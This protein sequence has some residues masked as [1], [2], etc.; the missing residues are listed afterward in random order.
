MEEYI[1]NYNLE[2][3]SSVVQGRIIEINGTILEKVLCLLIGEIAVGGDDSSDFSP[4]RYFK[5]VCR[6]LRGAKRIVLTEE[7]EHELAECCI[8][9]KGKFDL[10]EYKDDDKGPGHYTKGHWA[11]ATT[12]T[13]VKMEDLEEPV[14]ALIDHGSEINIMS[15]EVY[16][17][18]RWPIDINHGWEIRTANNTQ[19]DLYGACP[20][21]K[22]KVGDV[23][24]EQ[25]FFVQETTSYSVILGQPYITAVRMETKVLDDGSACARIRS[26]DGKKTVQFL[27]VLTNHEHNRNYLRSD[28]L[29]RVSEEFKDF[30]TLVFPQGRLLEGI[31]LK[32]A[33]LKHISQIYCMVQALDIKGSSKQDLEDSKKV[34]SEQNRR[35]EE[36][37]WTINEIGESKL[38]LEQKLVHQYEFWTKE[39]EHILRIV[40]GQWKKLIQNHKTWN[41]KW[42]KLKCQVQAERDKAELLTKEKRNIE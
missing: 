4:G 36:Q 24:T 17:R 5:E 21:M 29:P 19:G 6:P 18:G 28:L 10:D 39:K 38:I 26:Q 15:K 20:N 27:T 22:V 7:E 14:I 8:N 2:D 3:G 41:L 25:K 34:I 33:L 35:I 30:C 16:K 23:A 37:E 1:T 11:R 13:L 32:N 42:E 9:K 31:P 40:E 12:E